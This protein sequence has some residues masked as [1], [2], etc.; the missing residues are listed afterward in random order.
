[1]SSKRDGFSA[2]GE[3]WT[4]TASE[5]TYTVS[6]GALNS[7]QPTNHVDNDSAEVTSAGR[8]FQ[9]RGPTTWKTR[10][11]TDDSLTGGTTRRLVSA[12]R[13]D[14]QPGWSATPLSGPR[15]CRWRRHRKT[16]SGVEFRDKKEYISPCNTYSRIHLKE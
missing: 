8:S 11:V 3:M 9:I 16:N 12:E 2:T 1:M 7:A 14:R 10:L 4:M 15:Y 13:R 6:G 5:M